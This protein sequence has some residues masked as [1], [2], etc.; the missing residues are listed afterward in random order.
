[1][2][3]PY[4][5]YST[6]YLS[7]KT[8]LIHFRCIALL[9]ICYSLQKSKKLHF[10]RG[11]QACVRARPALGLPGEHHRCAPQSNPGPAVIAPQSGY[12]QRGLVV[13]TKNSGWDGKN[14]KCQI[15]R[16]S[17]MFMAAVVILQTG[18][19]YRRRQYW[20]LVTHWHSLDSKHQQWLLRSLVTLGSRFEQAGFLIW[21][22]T[23][24]NAAGCSVCGS[25]ILVN[26]HGSDT[27]SKHQCDLD[28]AAGSG[29]VNDEFVVRSWDN[30]VDH[31]LF[32]T[33]DV[34]NVNLSDWSVH[35]CACVRACIH[36]FNH[37]SAVTYPTMCCDVI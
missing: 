12:G 14:S 25:D 10:V 11:C 30:G 34:V 21:M 32:S 9:Q 35:V 3:F 1:M 5:F 7:Q 4:L 22:V 27:D 6:Q 20:V 29:C 19:R 31:Q 24:G 8:I 18:Q 17:L 2:K 16:E 23:M 37:W 33:E 15:G 13:V 26:S 28:G 36:V